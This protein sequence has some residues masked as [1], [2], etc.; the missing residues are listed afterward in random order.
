MRRI[1][2]GKGVHG[3]WVLAAGLAPGTNFCARPHDMC[4]G[5]DSF[6]CVGIDKEGLFVYRS[7]MQR[8]GKVPLLCA[9]VRGGVGGPDRDPKGDRGN[10]NDVR[11]DGRI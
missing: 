5:E 11:K 8:D 1:G 7:I 6:S 2:E 10:V 3:G 4:R 9:G